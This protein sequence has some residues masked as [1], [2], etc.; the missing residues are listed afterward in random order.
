MDVEQMCVIAIDPI[1]LIEQTVNDWFYDSSLK[2]V[3][4]HERIPS[5]SFA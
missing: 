1:K 2:L 5:E 3:S 4:V